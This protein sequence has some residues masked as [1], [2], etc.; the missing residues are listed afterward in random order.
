MCQCTCFCESPSLISSK[1]ER[2]PNLVTLKV[3][4]HCTTHSLLLNVE[5][6]CLTR[7]SGSTQALEAQERGVWG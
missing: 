7:S 5:S 4:A 6:V 2:E 3:A 1:S